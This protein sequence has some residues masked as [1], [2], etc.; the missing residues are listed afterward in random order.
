M[1]NRFLLYIDILGF[2]DLVLRNESMLE[3]LFGVIKKLNVHRHPSFRSIVFSDT[4]LA[5]NIEEFT[6]KADRDYA[7]MFL[8]EFVQQLHH[9]LAG[10]GIFFRAIVTEGA[11]VHDYSTKGI[12]CF[13][14]EALIKAYHLE[15]AAQVCG[16]LIDNACNE[17]N[18][19]FETVPIDEKSNYVF[20][21]QALERVERL[22][23]VPIPD[24]AFEEDWAW[25]FVP[26]VLS[27]AETYRIAHSI[28]DPRIRF[29]HVTT[30]EFYRQQYPRLCAYL[31]SHAFAF[32]ALNAS[33]NWR[34]FLDR[35]PEFP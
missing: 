25:A 34:Q 12:D 1:E 16:L 30:W 32:E 22:W 33:Y 13:Y 15:K 3:G 14:G 29:K 35:Y 27:L 19:I 23:G 4:I 24:I 17:H 6:T 20:I 31:E 28:N 8:C 5:Y 21:T 18:N 11:F 2:T 10:S 26:E 7:V 9:R